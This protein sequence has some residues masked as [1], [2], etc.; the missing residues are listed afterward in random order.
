[1]QKLSYGVNGSG[2]PAQHDALSLREVPDMEA[3]S[4]ERVERQSQAELLVELAN[5]AELFHTEERIAYATVPVNGH[6]ENWRLRSKD[7]KL[8]LLGLFYRKYKGSPRA[9]ALQDALSTI[10]ARAIYDGQ[11]RSVAVRIASHS[12]KIYLD[13]ADREW[14]AVEI[15]KSGWRVLQTPPV[16]FVRSRGM[17]PLPVPKTGGDPDR[18]CVAG[19][20]PSTQKPLAVT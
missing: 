5:D 4:E 14:Q 20:D 11:E 10:D 1:M 15:D 7:F 17:E 9:Q 18:H 6:R 13:L 2:D 3:S 8:W 19:I 12:G 16:A